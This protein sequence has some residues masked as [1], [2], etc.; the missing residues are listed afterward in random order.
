MKYED[1]EKYFGLQELEAHFAVTLR[2]LLFGW[3]QL[4]GL[5]WVIDWNPMQ[6]IH[7]ALIG[8]TAKKNVKQEGLKAAQ[9]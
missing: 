1:Q 6:Q 4:W 3:L 8:S 2:Q 5:V 7:T 9:A